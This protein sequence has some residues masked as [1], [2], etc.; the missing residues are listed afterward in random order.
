L[1]IESGVML[2]YT[3]KYMVIGACCS[4]AMATVQL[5]LGQYKT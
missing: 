3:L 4:V 2:R 5:D 1:V